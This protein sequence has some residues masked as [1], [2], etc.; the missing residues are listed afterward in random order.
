MQQAGVSVS[1]LQSLGL[2]GQPTTTTTGPGG[3]QIPPNQAWSPGQ[4]QNAAMVRMMMKLG[5]GGQQQQAPPPANAY[6]TAFP[7]YAQDAQGNPTGQPIYANPTNQASLLGAAA[8][9]MPAV[10]NPPPSAAL[11][12]RSGVSKVG[13]A[14]IGT[15]VPQVGWGTTGGQGGANWT[16]LGQAAG[17]SPADIAAFQRQGLTPEQAAKQFN[18][19]APLAGPWTTQPGIFTA[20]PRTAPTQA[21][22]ATP[23]QAAGQPTATAYSPTAAPFA[24]PPPAPGFQ[25]PQTPF[26]AAHTNALADAGKAL[27][28]HFGGDPNSAGPADIANFHSQLTSALAAAPQPTAAK[29]MASGGF[30]QGFDDGGPVED[31]NA[32]PEARRKTL[33]TSASQ[34]TTPTQP[35]SSSSSSAQS[36][37]PPAAPGGGQNAL[38][39]GLTQAVHA[40]S[41]SLSG[42]GTPYYSPGQGVWIGA[43][44]GAG[45]SGFAYAN[46]AAAAADPGATGKG[47]IGMGGGQLQSALGGIGSGL[48]QAAQAIASSVHPWQMQQSAIP[49]P[50][51][52]PA[53]PQLTQPPAPQQTQQQVNPYVAYA[54]NQARYPISPYYT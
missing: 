48:T 22:G 16:A 46:Q 19:Q 34:P 8:L 32:P 17:F 42:R 31:P 39:S 26:V 5:G 47:A 54:A 53:A 6:G 35:T 38:A 11:D 43:S 18:V 30:V 29:K 36:S 15:S 33:T 40:Y 2:V 51:P 12:P 44:P 25:S 45:Q 14:L 28:A 1:D 3:A 24:T 20:A 7:L 23:L 50:P 4:Q 27:F 13:G 9:Q 49:A 37:A 52:A 41:N 10:I 21:L